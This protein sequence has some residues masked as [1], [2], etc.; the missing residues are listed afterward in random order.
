MPG[1][2]SCLALDE[3]G[4]PHIAYWRY[5]RDAHALKYAFKK[6]NRWH[7]SVVDPSG[8]RGVDFALALDSSGNPHISYGRESEG[9]R[10]SYPDLRYAFYDG[11]NWQIETVDKQ[12]YS[13]F[14]NSIVVD[15]S[16]NPHI[17]YQGPNNI[18]QLKYASR[19]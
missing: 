7:I 5:V 1:T 11:Q 4:N 9:V 14:Y 18:G 3:A 2:T 10:Y 19:K 15:E 6:D 17:S 12:G 16:G 8:F 13:G